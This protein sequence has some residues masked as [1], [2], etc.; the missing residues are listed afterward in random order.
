MTSIRQ[1]SIRLS[2]IAGI[3]LFLH[4]SWFL[5]AAFEISGRAQTYSSLTWNALEYLALF[6]I[7]TLHEYGHA[8]ACRQVGGTANQIVLWPLGGVAYVDPPPRPG[9]TLWSIAAGPLVNVA[10]LPILTVLV[11]L[12][13]GSGWANVF[14]NAHTW[15]W[16][17]WFINLGLLAFNMLPIY[18]LD[19]GQILRSLL[20]FVLGRAR[21]L[22]VAT[23]IGFV[24]VAGLI[25][26]ALW[27]RSVWF[28]VL[29]V[30]ILTNCWGGL[31][32]AQAL[33][34]LAKLPRHEGFACPWCKSAPPIGEFWACGQ[35]GK[36]LDTFQ[37]GAVCPYCGARFAAT[38]CVDCGK[39][40]PMSDW[41]LAP[42][43]STPTGTLVGNWKP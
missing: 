32:H 25:L 34:R 4:W 15:L 35:C 38:R 8:L 1:G 28:G 24:G 13:R 37:T 10:L 40:H 26:L 5:V 29:S 23:I 9:A 11:L 21:S 42:L 14:P 20:W 43:G 18:P 22:M 31:R 3:D 33:S 30:F 39:Q 12:S 7:V 41:V 17:V 6:F 36:P 27:M 19:G 16:T 2:R